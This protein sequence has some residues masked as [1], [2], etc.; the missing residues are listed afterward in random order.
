MIYSSTKRYG[1]EQGLSCCFRQHRAESHC[2]MLHG[3]AIAVTLTFSARDL[4]NNNW[5]VDFG[6]LKPVKQFLVETFDHKLLVAT[7]D[8]NLDELESL[9][10]DWGLANVVLVHE[11]GCEAFAD[12]IAAWVQNWLAVQHGSRVWL[13]SCTVSEHAGNHATVAFE[14]PNEK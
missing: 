11:T 12:Y 3:Y 10:I 14:E 13:S 9:S 1:H 4:D 7:S 2:R 8:P 6:S 5:V